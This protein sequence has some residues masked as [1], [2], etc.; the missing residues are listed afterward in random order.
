MPRPREVTVRT[1][2][3]VSIRK[4]RGMTQRQ[5]AEATDGAVSVGMLAQIETGGRRPSLVNAKA[6][7]AAL[8]C[9]VTEFCE[10]HVEDA[11]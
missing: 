9:H 2:A 8:G 1:V 3:L 10:L 7:A 6:L 11:A 4:Q 5:L